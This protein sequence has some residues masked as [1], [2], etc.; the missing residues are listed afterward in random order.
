MTNDFERSYSPFIE[1]LLKRKVIAPVALDV[2]KLTSIAD[3]FIIC[4]GRSTRQVSAIAEFVL[5]DLKEAGIR[6]I[7][8]EGIREGQWAL[9]D[10]GHVIIHIFFEP[11][12][13]V[14]DIE[15]LWVD[16]A[17]IDLGDLRIT[18]ATET[19]EAFHEE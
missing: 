13:V 12:R 7:G 18:E 2:R 15:G 5:K 17:R 9:L 1:A 4:S 14:Y 3:V 10:Y 19:S 11:V 6:S 8:S 16:A